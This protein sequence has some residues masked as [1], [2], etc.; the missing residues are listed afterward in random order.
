MPSYDDLVSVV[1]TCLISVCVVHFTCAWAGCLI[2]VVACFLIYVVACC[3]VCVVACCLVCIV[4]S[5]LLCK[6]K[7]VRFLVRFMTLA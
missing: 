3:L 6:R 7:Y 2:C 4:L 1:A 5:R